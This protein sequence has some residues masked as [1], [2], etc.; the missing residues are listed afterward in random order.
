MSPQP[1]PHLLPAEGVV[2]WKFLQRYG[3]QW[4]SFDY[5]VRIGR[6]RPPDSTAPPEI[7]AM[8]TQLSK[9]RIDAVGWQG[10]QPT[11][12]EISPRGSR[13]VI[14][15]LHL[16][17][18]LFGETFPDVLAPRLAAVVGSIDPDGLRYFQAK[19]VDVFAL[20]EP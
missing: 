10:R 11:I 12:F 17:E 6:G 15:A 18:W 7:Q 3:Q 1:F 20:G 8:W 5:D 4:D 13:T 16:Y 14:G 2:W 9:K 19:G